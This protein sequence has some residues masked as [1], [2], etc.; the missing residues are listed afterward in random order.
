MGLWET[1]QLTLTAEL[2]S[3]I[4]AAA[5]EA[6]RRRH[7]EVTVTHLLWAL[8]RSPELSGQVVAMGLEPSRIVGALE[9]R[10]SAFPR[11]DWL[12]FKPP[13]ST[14]V[15]AVQAAVAMSAATASPRSPLL[16]APEN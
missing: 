9:G 12:K 15:P 11:F 13:V 5:A 7:R 1:P 16:L 6:S 14:F 2:K 10:M 3:S 4:A 8:F